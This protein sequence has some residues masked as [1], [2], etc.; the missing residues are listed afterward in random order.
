MLDEDKRALFYLSG[1]V[2]QQYYYPDIPAPCTRDRAV[3]IGLPEYRKLRYEGK[4]RK[5]LDDPSVRMKIED[6]AAR[7]IIE[8]SINL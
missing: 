3:L 6:L 1:I 2:V 8:L 5:Y 4:I 7:L